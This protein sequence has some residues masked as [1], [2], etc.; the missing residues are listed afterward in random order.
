MADTPKMF[1]DIEALVGGGT[2]T[3]K[4]G[5]MMQGPGVKQAGLWLML[6]WLAQKYLNTRNKSKMRDIEIE[7]MQGQAEAMSPENLYYQA[8]LPQAQQEEES[9]RQALMSQIMGGVIGPSLARGET[10]I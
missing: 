10:Q 6:P 9:A 7:G 8:S 2:K 1:D 3:S 5:G 4:L